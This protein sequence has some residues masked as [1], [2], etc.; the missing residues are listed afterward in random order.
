[1]WKWMIIA[2]LSPVFCALAECIREL[3]NFVV[4]HYEVV[5]EKLEKLE[6]E[7]RIVVL[8]DLH[9]KAYGKNN[10]KLFDAVK[11]QQ[12]DMIL[13]AGDMII[14]KKGEEPTNALDL[15]CRLPQI[16]PVYY[17]NGNHE[18]RM[19]EDRDRYGDVFPNYK[20]KIQ[21]AGVILLENTFVNVD[22]GGVPAQVHGLELPIK[23]YRKLKHHRVEGEQISQCLGQADKGKYQ[24]LIAHNPVLFQAYKEWGADLTVSGHLHGGIIRI[25]GFRG[26]IT[27]QARLFPKYSGELSR[28]DGQT[29]VVSKGLGTHTVNVRL[30]NPAEVVVLHVKGSS[31]SK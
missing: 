8:S 30:F 23:L 21:K 14:G 13:I 3:H 1:M 9:S 22:L 31:D 27:P 7:K 29:L 18:Q 2:I 15:V 11:R 6:G 19:K 26:V 5:S 10:Q 12:P 16:C 20:K 28:E 24:I 4:T 25:P 17:G